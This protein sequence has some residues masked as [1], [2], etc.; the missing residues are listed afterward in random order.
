VIRTAYCWLLSKTSR[1][2]S[3][4]QFIS[5]IDGLRF[6]A[7]FTVLIFHVFEYLS[8]KID[9]HGDNLLVKLISHGKIGVQLFFVI[10]G[11]V[12]ALPF[13]KGHFTGGK[14]PKIK[15]YFFR[16]L[17]RLEPPYIV[18]LVIMYLILISVT[19]QKTIE[20]FPHFLA[21]L[22]YLHNIIY[23]RMSDINHV[24]WSLEIELQ[25]YVM[26]PIVTT[27]FMIRSN[28]KRRGLL[29]AAIAAFSIM[30]FIIDN[31]ARY[32]LSILSQAQF[33]LTGFLLVDVYLTE[34]N[35]KPIKSVQWD[36]VSVLA[37]LAIAALLFAG[38]SGML[39]IM[40]PMFLAYCAAFKGT[41]S[42]RFFCNPIIYTIGGMC[43]T[44]YLYHAQMISAFGKLLLKTGILNNISFMSAI[45]VATLILVP[46]VLLL[47]SLFFIYIEKPCMKKGWYLQ[48]YERIIPVSKK[49]VATEE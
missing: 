47:C 12:I 7:I 27:V 21:S 38:R 40:V 33:F 8:R 3:T 2:T 41:W 11:F 5:E 16:R 24:A 22:G 44:I 29:V 48:L 28:M 15:Q 17:T 30:G 25:F 9:A 6:I 10:S 45:M 35:Q 26:A 43:Y 36:V 23:G 32:S 19:S 14:L 13:A 34:W 4:G 39:F 20:L 1:D 37:W 46:F 49:E 18:N 31:S 42:N